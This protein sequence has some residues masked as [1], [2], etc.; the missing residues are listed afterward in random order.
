MGQYLF[1]YTV[2]GVLAVI[3]LLLLARPIKW[4]FKII[5][6]CA[7]GCIGLIAFNLF[8][9]LLGLYIGVNFLTAVTVG[10]LGMPGL[11]MLLLLQ[12][13]V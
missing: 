13:I 2:G 6:N 1:A 5:I 9:G 7:I 10:L 11:A 8:G 3:A 4:A 12:R